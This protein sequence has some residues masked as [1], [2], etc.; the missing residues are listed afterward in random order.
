M[1]K[2]GIASR[3]KSVVFRIVL[4]TGLA[5]LLPLCLRAQALQMYPGIEHGFGGYR[6]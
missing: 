4:M 3:L 1:Y 6:I 5:M 2:V